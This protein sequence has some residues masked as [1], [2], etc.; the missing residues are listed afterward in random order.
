[1][2]K[3]PSACRARHR[4]PNVLTVNVGDGERGG[5]SSLNTK[6]CHVTILTGCYRHKY[7]QSRVQRL[8]KMESLL[9]SSTLPQQG[10]AVTGNQSETDGHWEEV[11][12]QPVPSLDLR[13]ELV[14]KDSTAASSSYIQPSSISKTTTAGPSA[15]QT[16]FRDFTTVDL[17]RPQGNSSI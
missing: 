4:T 16:S 2:A 9:E 6:W 13:S 7:I 12:D 10:T 17:E 14:S 11:F 15:I 8:E 5:R 1:M 3:H